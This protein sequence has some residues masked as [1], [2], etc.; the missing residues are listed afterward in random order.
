MPRTTAKALDLPLIKTF[1]KC[2]LMDSKQVPLV[3][4]IKDAQVYLPTFPKKRIKLTILVADIPTSYGML[5]SQ[6]LCQHLGEVKMDWS[7]AI[8]PI[9]KEKVTLLPEAKSKYI[10]FPSD[11]P[12]SQILYHK[13]NFYNYLI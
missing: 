6:T 2:Y 9:G 12:K 1:G 8:I 5:L 13:T 7:Q 4:Q 11:D 3:G 10:V